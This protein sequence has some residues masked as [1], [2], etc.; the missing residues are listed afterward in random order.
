[1]HE[2]ELYGFSLFETFL[3]KQGRFWQ[4]DAHW[5]RLNTSASRFGMDA[6]DL[7]RFMR[8]V[9]AYHD[10]GRD[11]IIRNTLLQTGGRWTSQAIACETRILKKAWQ[12]SEPRP[13]RLHLEER[14][15]PVRDEMRTHKSGAR[16]HYQ[17][18]YHAAR[19]RGYDDCLFQDN[20][21]YLLESSTHS[22]CLLMD[23]HWVTPPL[24]RG[25]LPGVARGWLIAEHG[26]VERDVRAAD[27]ENCEAAVAANAVRGLL[28]VSALGSRMP[29]TSEAEAFIERIGGR[30]FA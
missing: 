30:N 26:L 18:C 1:M 10:A 17:A 7:D 22:L 16:M 12:P 4:L 21:G 6:P 25:I 28:P 19:S 15:L 8:E 24:A 9:G 3:A 2:Y 14:P 11:E 13:L 23:G 20:E 27:L 5:N 29:A